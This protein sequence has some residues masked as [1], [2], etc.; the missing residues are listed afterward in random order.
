MKINRISQVKLFRILHQAPE[1]IAIQALN[2][3]WVRTVFKYV[4][5]QLFKQARVVVIMMRATAK[6]AHFAPSQ[7][8]QPELP[9]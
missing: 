6:P 8:I 9:V 2:A 3:L 7:A 5:L 1:N 4:F